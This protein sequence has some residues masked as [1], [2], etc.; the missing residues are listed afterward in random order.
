MGIVSK[1]SWRLKLLHSKLMGREIA[2][3]RAVVKEIL[4]SHSPQP[5]RGSFSFKRQGDFFLVS[6]P[7]GARGVGAGHGNA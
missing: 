4:R 2:G 1:L 7:N 6:A 3:W 5:K